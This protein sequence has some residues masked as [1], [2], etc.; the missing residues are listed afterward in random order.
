MKKISKKQKILIL[1]LILILL[2]IVIIGTLIKT[3]TIKINILTSIFKSANNDSSS[4]SLLP[5][6]IKEGITLGGITGTLEDLDTSDATATAEDI[7]YGKTAYVDGQKITGTY[8]TLG[9]LQV[10]DYVA[11][12]SDTDNTVYSLSSE[13]TGYASSQTISKENL[14]WRIL[15]INENGTVDLI[16]SGPTSGTI[17]LTD[18]VG[19]NNGVYLLN[20]ISAK[21]YSNNSLKV[22]ARSINIED[23]EKHMN[24][25]GLE[26]V[27]SYSVGGLKWG[28]TMTYTSSSYRYYPNLYAKE[29]GSGINTTKVKTDGIGQSDSYYA[30]ATKETYSQAGS[31]GLTITQ[32]YYDRT[33][34]KDYYDSEVFYNLIHN[35]GNEYWLASRHVSPY[36]NTIDA[37]FGLRRVSNS[38]LGGRDLFYSSINV[39]LGDAYCLRP[40]VSLKSNIKI[41]SGDGKSA[42]TAYEIIY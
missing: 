9:M 24:E 39:N 34:T 31:Q 42:N 13:Y 29:N 8:R 33:M 1:I 3:N 37:N 2:I 27:H 16:S 38:S 5:E 15:S 30:E 28:E 23:I 17:G 41:G 35:A 40:L 10:G 32:T 25:K 22:T 6:Y 21:L 36:T 20:D 12:T 4:G 26:Y 19:Y 18:A 7:L 14:S 11:Y